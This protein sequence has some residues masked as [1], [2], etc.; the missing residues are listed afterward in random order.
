MDG[1]PL[2]AERLADSSLVVTATVGTKSGGSYALPQVRMEGSMVSSITLGSL[3][4]V[5]SVSIDTAN[6]SFFFYQHFVA[7]SPKHLR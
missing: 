5:F 3:V 7:I 6:D 4:V 2:E 1:E